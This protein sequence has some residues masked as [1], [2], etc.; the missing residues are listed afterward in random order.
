MQGGWCDH[1]EEK[2][3]FVIQNITFMDLNP[4]LNKEIFIL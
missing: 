1:R 3:S 2:K 4:V